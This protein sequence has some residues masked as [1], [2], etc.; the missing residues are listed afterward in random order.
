[1]CL[2][3]CVFRRNRSGEAAKIKI[4]TSKGVC[5]GNALDVL[6]VSN[7]CSVHSYLHVKRNYFFWLRNRTPIRILFRDMLIVKY[8]LVARWHISL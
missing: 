4:R 3:V 1:M 6:L 5:G 8:V 7:P 2:C